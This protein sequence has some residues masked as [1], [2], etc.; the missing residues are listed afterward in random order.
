[1]DP[2]PPLHVVRR[3]ENVE[4]NARSDH[5]VPADNDVNDE[6][7]EMLSYGRQYHVLMKDCIIWRFEL[8]D[9]C[10]MWKD[11]ARLPSRLRTNRGGE[12]VDYI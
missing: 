1:M 9:M 2:F 7:N 8:N 10:I 5:V 12:N 11:Q 3:R 6:L 4:R